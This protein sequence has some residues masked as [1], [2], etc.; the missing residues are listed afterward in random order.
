MLMENF[1]VMVAKTTAISY[2]QNPYA[3]WNW[4]VVTV[5]QIVR[6]ELQVGSG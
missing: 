5:T 3:V 1:L 4:Y 2:Q 6:I